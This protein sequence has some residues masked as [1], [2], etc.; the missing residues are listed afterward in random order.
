MDVMLS[1]IFL[2]AFDFHN[3]CIKKKISQ[4]LMSVFYDHGAKTLT[5]HN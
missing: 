1:L 5:N 2:D 3:Y 4:V